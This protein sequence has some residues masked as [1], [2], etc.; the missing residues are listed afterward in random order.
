M[1]A[2]ARSTLLAATWA[3]SR[4]DMSRVKAGDGF[5]VFA[6]AIGSSSLSAS[7]ALPVSRW[8][9]AMSQALSIRP[10]SA[11]ALPAS[12]PRLERRGQAPSA[13][14]TSASASFSASGVLASRSDQALLPVRRRRRL[15]CA[16]IHLAEFERTDSYAAI[17]LGYS[18]KPW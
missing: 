8:M 2:S 14:L 12:L 9:S 4:S 13:F 7:S 11:A 6:L 3:R 1:S 17:A 5:G 10:G 15:V 18:P 16:S